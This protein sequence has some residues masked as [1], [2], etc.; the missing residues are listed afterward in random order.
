[1]RRL[2]A[3]LRCFASGIRRLIKG[4]AARLRTANDRASAIIVALYPNLFS[5]AVVMMG[6][7]APPVPVPAYM[8]PVASPRRSWNHSKMLVAHGMYVAAEHG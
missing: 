7:S 3:P 8:M 6:Y 4:R 5:R 1:M 2:E